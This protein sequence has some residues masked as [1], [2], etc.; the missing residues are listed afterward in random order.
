MIS[1][2]YI[3]VSPIKYIQRSHWIIRPK[4]LLFPNRTG[5]GS[6]IIRLPSRSCAKAG[7]NPLGSGH[8]LKRNVN[9][10]GTGWA[11]M[12]KLHHD[13]NV[14]V[15]FLFHKGTNSTARK[16]P[17]LRRT[18]QSRVQCAAFQGKMFGW[19]NGKVCI[20]MLLPQ[21]CCQ[22]RPLILFRCLN[23]GLGT[24]NPF[25]LIKNPT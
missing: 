21:V 19:S 4:G 9:P 14:P 20:V 8:F 6:I 25:V 13:V 16:Q 18:E 2:I 1:S 22:Y 5:E 15:V 10:V 7:R 11:P 3:L 24:Q 17:S 23:S 12:V